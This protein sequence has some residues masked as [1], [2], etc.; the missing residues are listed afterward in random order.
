MQVIND[1][2]LFSINT[3]TAVLEGMVDAYF[4]A[5]S[6]FT[7][8]DVATFRSVASEWSRTPTSGYG[9]W[10]LVQQRAATG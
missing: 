8:N 9:A 5:A 3:T 10:G 2:T 6:F 4:P 7:L 1:L